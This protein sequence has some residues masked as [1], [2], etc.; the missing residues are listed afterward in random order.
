MRGSTLCREAARRENLGA[1]SAGGRSK[2]PKADTG[3]R[4]EILS[5][6]FFSEEEH[7]W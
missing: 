6:N 4:R 5:V 1:P 7:C 3:S 2:R